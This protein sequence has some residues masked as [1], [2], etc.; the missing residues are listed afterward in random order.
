MPAP[1]DLDPLL[2]TVTSQLPSIAGI[3]D[4][5]TL[6]IA[7][8]NSGLGGRSSSSKRLQ[9]ALHAAHAMYGAP[10][11]P[12]HTAHRQPSVSLQHYL[13]RVPG[14]N[15]WASRAMHQSHHSQLFPRALSSLV[16]IMAFSEAPP[17]MDL[18]SF[19][20]THINRNKGLGPEQL[21]LFIQAVL[22]FPKDIQVCQH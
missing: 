11:H 14:T 20:D 21:K 17:H 18:V 6:R 3:E 13:A 19:M 8:L 12:T 16:Q 5:A 10:A 1:Y 4:P 7:K 15:V 2:R 22:E 9:Q